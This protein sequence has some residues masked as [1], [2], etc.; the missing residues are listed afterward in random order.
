[1]L[2]IEKCALS[3]PR[4]APFRRNSTTW[5]LL[6]TV[7]S[8]N[9]NIQQAVLSLKTTCLGYSSIMRFISSQFEA[10]TLIVLDGAKKSEKIIKPS[11]DVMSALFALANIRM[12][13][14][15]AGYPKDAGT[16]PNGYRKVL[17]GKNRSA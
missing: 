11:P 10:G 12:E 1:M 14:R 5:E 3:D 7:A 17:A 8:A 2:E 9:L 4:L 16:G 15:G 6:L 13:E